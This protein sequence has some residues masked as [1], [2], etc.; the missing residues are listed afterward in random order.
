LHITER[1]TRVDKDTINYEA[2]I[3]DPKVFTKPFTSSTTLMLWKCTLASTSVLRI[4]KTSC[5]MKSCS[6]GPECFEKALR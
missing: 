3:E 2:T 4:T 6:S 1:Y 5:G